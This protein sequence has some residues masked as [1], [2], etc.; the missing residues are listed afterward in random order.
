M[1]LFVLLLFLNVS[2]SA[3]KRWTHISG[4]DILIYSCMTVSGAADGV[5]QAITHHEF[6]RTRKFWDFQTSW[7][8]KYKNIDER[9]TRAAF[10]GSKDIFVGFTDGYHLSRFIDRAFT[11]TSVCFSA[12]ELKQYEKK[13]RW[14]VIAKK[15][16]LSALFNRLAFNLTFNKLS[17]PF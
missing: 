6:G 14:K 4:N 10:F 8:N 3:Q 9:D 2:V 7:K 13:D 5:N 15:A 11:L 1:K 17:G 12:S 16:V